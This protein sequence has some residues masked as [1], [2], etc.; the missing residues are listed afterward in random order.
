MSFRSFE[1]RQM[2]LGVRCVL[3]VSMHSRASVLSPIVVTWTVNTHVHSWKSMRGG[4]TGRKG[5]KKWDVGGSGCRSFQAVANEY[6]VLEA[7]EDINTNTELS[8]CLRWKG[9]SSRCG[10]DRAASRRAQRWTGIILVMY[11]ILE[12]APQK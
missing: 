12:T 10:N 11:H 6:R 3:P 5:I 4:E 7:G 9:C 8:R 2:Q 1:G